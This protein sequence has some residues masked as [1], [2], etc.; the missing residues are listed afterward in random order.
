M[1]QSLEALLTG[2]LQPSLYRCSSRTRART[3]TRLA[4]QHGW[5]VFS[6]DGCVIG[7][8]AEFLSQSAAVM[9]F[10][11]YFGQ[12]W[13]ALEECLNDMSW[14]PR[15]PALLLF[16]AAGRFAA[17]D[18]DE[19]A[20]A[21]DILAAATAHRRAGPAPLAVLLRGAGRAAAHLP[22]LRIEDCQD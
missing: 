1:T 4:E 17:A 16:D 6:L 18:P 12:N 7:G 15:Q 3:I 14:E 2:A 21:L 11:A 22:G 20:T 5:R 13:D 19:F 8:K 9:H 10:P